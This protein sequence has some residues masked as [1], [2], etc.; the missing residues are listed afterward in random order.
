MIGGPR[1]RSARTSFGFLRLTLSI[2]AMLV[3]PFGKEGDFASNF[4]ADQRGAQW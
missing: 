2:L 3:R 4:Q 1:R